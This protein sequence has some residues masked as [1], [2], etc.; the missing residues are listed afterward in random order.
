MRFETR[1]RR[2][3]DRCTESSIKTY[4]ANVK[5]LARLAGRSD[6]P[7][8]DSSWLD[9]ALLATIKLEGPGRFKRFAIAG[10][11]AVQAYGLTQDVQWAQ[12]VVD[13]T[14]RYESFRNQQKKTGREAENWPED[15]YA[16]LR[17]LANTLYEEPGGTRSILEAG[18][19]E[20]ATA[21]DLYNIQRHFV[22]LF[23][24]WHALRGD[25]AEARIEPKGQNYIYEKSGKWCLHIGTHKTV[26]DFELAP[27]AELTSH[28]FLLSTM[29]TGRRMNRRDMLKMIRKVT[30]ERLGCNLGVQMIRVLRVSA[31]AEQINE[32]TELRRQMAHG[33]AT[34]FQ[35]VS[36]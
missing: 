35:Y 25:L 20:N 23:Y 30:K 3:C 31:A 19:P 24:A 10:R 18:K 14:V 13:A 34:Q 16:A 6:V 4:L 36:K 33:A 12:A 29:R 5:A 1:L 21:S 28:G 8:S 7:D 11:K 22:I 17:R 27:V 26:I 15:G 2:V 32:T 9:G